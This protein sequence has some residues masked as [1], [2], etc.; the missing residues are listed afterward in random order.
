MKQRKD[1]KVYADAIATWGPDFQVIKIREEMGELQ[2]AMARYEFG[3]ESID[4]VIDEVADVTIMMHQAR[5]IFG[6]G[7]VDAAIERKLARLSDK[8]AS[9]RSRGKAK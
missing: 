8:I 4:A 7:L 9:A 1:R 3:R 5:L 6:A 2:T